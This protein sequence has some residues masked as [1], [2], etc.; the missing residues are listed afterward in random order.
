MWTRNGFMLANFITS[1]SGIME[2][3][4]NRN[5][6]TQK[7]RCASFEFSEAKN[8]NK[9][10]TKMEETQKFRTILSYFCIFGRGPLMDG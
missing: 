2:A 5:K 8:Q 6:N 10:E 3:K 7:T 9:E 1:C 4:K